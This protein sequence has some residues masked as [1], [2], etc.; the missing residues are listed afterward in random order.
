MDGGLGAG[1][2]KP[3]S[4]TLLR[5]VGPKWSG[6]VVCPIA[7]METLWQRSHSHLERRPGFDKN[8]WRMTSL[9]LSCEPM[10]GQ[11]ASTIRPLLRWAGGKRWLVPGVANLLGEVAIQNYHEPFVGGGAIFFGL[12]INTKAYLTDLNSDLIDTY[13]EV[14]DEPDE[15]WRFL[16]QYQNTEADY[17]AARTARLRLPASRAARFIFLNH[18]S[19]N[20]IYRVNLSGQYNVPYGYRDHFNPPNLEDLREA[21][22]RLQSAVLAS[23]DFETALDFIGPGDLVFLDPPYTAAH[24]NN[25]FVKYNDKLFLFSDQHRLSSMIDDIRGMDAYYILTNAAHHS[26]AKLFKK[27]D[28]RLK[29]SRKNAVGGRDALRGRA[30][31]YLFTNLPEA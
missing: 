21:S 15:V 17:Y 9:R 11:D 22:S 25:G 6:L 7:E 30:T 23:G 8:P 18:A 2:L 31:E 5:S 14:R 19:F 28:R 13:R 1:V 10:S 29:T 27:G 26:I 16:R 20:G 4:N 24:N 3:P 12:S